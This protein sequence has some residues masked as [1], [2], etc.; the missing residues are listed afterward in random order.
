M[1]IKNIEGK[2]SKILVPKEPDFEFVYDLLL[3]YGKA[4]PSITRL[5]KG[6]Y[7]LATDKDTE[8]YWKNN[9]LFKHVPHQDL[10]ETIDDLK[11]SKYGTKYSP[12]FVIVTDF[13]QLLAVDMRTEETLD[14]PLAEIAKHYAFFLPWAGMEKSQIQTENEAD[15]KAAVRMARLYDE[16]IRIEANPVN[17]SKFLHALNIFFSRLL[18]CFFAEDTE[19]FG[20]SQFTGSISSY[21]QL[22]GSDLNGY[23]DELFAALDVEDKSTYPAHIAAFPYVNGGLFNRQTP[24]PNFSAKARKLILECGEL[25]WSEINPDIFGS[26]IQAVV[27]PGQRAGLGMHYTSVVNI[28]KVIEPLFLEELKEELDHAFGDRQKL[29]KLLKRIY[30][31]KIFD[32]A[33]GSGNFLI[34][35]YK[36]LRKIEHEII[37]QLMEGKLAL[38]IN[39]GL[40]LE[41]FYGIEI[42]DFAREVAVLSLWLAKHQMNIEF[43]KKFGKDIPLIPLKD[44]GNIICDNATQA[45]WE[46]ICPTKKDEEVYL[47]G[48]PPYLGR[49]NQKKEH[50][51]DMDKSIKFLKNY[52]SLDYI[53]IWFVKGSRY[54]K[55]SKNSSLAFVTTNSINQGEQV[56]LLWPYLLEDA[57]IQ[58]AYTSFKWANHAAHNA[59]VTVAIVSLATAGT[60]KKKYIFEGNTRID[61]NY[62]NP[63]L[64]DAPTVYISRRSE[65]ISSLPKMSYGN[66]TGGCDALTMTPIE[67]EGIVSEY[68]H[69]K[70]LFRKLVG[71]AELNRGIDRYCLWIMN[72]DLDFANSIPPIKSRIDTV[73]EVR[74]K[75]EEPSIHALSNRPHQ[76]RDLKVAK[77]Q[78]LVVPIVFSERRRYIPCAFY[79]AD[80]IIPNSAQAIYDPETYIFSVISSRMHILWTKTVGGKLKT[81]YRYSSTTIYNNFPLPNL[82]DSQKKSLESHALEVMGARE[83]FSEKTLAELYDPNKMPEELLQAHN[84]L[85]EVFERCYRPRPFDSDED[86][87]A[88]LFK[89]YEIM[90]K[91]QKELI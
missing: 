25:N 47:I 16:I 13:D 76:F 29:E 60:R 12:R 14:I 78:T 23:L 21:T 24:S 45:N 79:A 34:I 49:R 43:K 85:D 90:T 8:I 42:D 17:D 72:P 1:N 39:S 69:S 66:L 84:D 18:F 52:R 10:H 33:C 35:A 15:I 56:A 70:R 57:E 9:L 75:N 81:D 31:I 50:K 53:A 55:Q 6:T 74:L 4:K 61:A 19:V 37:E 44:T 40:K 41:N 2:V 87:L 22:D 73:R 38:R 3:A 89:L 11:R 26:M 80:V 71:S 54:I 48:N 30:E 68:P 20:K 67:M 32:P 77:H 91:T 27:H 83:K 64:N 58:F 86:R 82:T 59:G 5:K 62:I 88:Y 51:D 65:P 28:M 46:E 36:E 7:N 63:Y